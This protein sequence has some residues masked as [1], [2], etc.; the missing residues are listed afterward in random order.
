MRVEGNAL[1]T[2][3]LA[4]EN[5]ENMKKAPKVPQKRKTKFCMFHLQGVCQFGAKCAFAHSVDEL[6]KDSEDTSSTTETISTTARPDEETRSVGV[7]MFYKKA[8]CSWYERGRCR[9]GEQ[10]SF[11]HGADELR[12]YGGDRQPKASVEK[13]EEMHRVAQRRPDVP[14]AGSRYSASGPV[15]ESDQVASA[16]SG[17][18]R[19]FTTYGAPGLENKDWIKGSSSN[20]FEPM[21]VEPMSSPM[22]AQPP[23]GLA[24]PPPG[25]TPQMIF[26]PAPSPADQQEAFYNMYASG[27]VNVQ[28]SSLVEGLKGLAAAPVEELRREWEMMEQNQ[29]FLEEA[30]TV[31]ADDFY[32]GAQGP[33]DSL[34]ANIHALLQPSEYK[35]RYLCAM[36]MQSQLVGA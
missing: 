34:N 6:Q 2:A 32:S 13:G 3:T 26:Q 25:L 28:P 36:D 10:C 11:A 17:G 27:T 30:A 33:W 15:A 14:R 8:P 31:A 16:A 12:K 7:G 5:P 22:S 23:P 29:K 18:S 4:S 1:R 35:A 9:K 24:M 19:T 20:L 21:F